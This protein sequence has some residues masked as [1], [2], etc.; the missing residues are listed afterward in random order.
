MRIG[1][2]SDTHI[3]DGKAPLPDALLRGLEAERVERILHAGDILVPEVLDR[4]RAVAP[5]DAVVGNNEDDWVADLLPEELSLT[6]GGVRI[7]L[8][9]GHH[10]PGNS[11][12]DR[13]YRHWLD[14]E[15]DVIVF[16]HSHWPVCEWRA[17]RLMLNP[18]SPTQPR[19]APH[20]SFAVL[21]IDED[22]PG[23]AGRIIQLPS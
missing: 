11:T 14:R 1:V 22:E 17:G 12:E 7:G 20:P 23:P 9:H 4:L 5:V 19:R 18:G 15:I 13:A 10:G 21:L 16:G 6:L 2:V 3:R 8:W